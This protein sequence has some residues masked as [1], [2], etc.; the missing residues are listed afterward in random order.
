MSDGP[1]RQ[2]AVT[3]PLENCNGSDAI[4]PGNSTA[5]PAAR[6]GEK[7]EQPQ[8]GRTRHPYRWQRAKPVRIPAE[9]QDASPH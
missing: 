7:P 1:E 5:L 2:K 4:I 8:L 9:G 3:K 6:K